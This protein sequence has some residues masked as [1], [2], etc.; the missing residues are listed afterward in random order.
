MKTYKRTDVVNYANK[1]YS[2]NNPD[3]TWFGKN[4]N[5]QQSPIGGNGDCANFVSQ[6]LFE[7]GLPFK[8]TGS[9]N[10]KWY[11]YTKGGAY[12]RK[13]SSWSGANDLRIFVHNTKN[14][15]RLNVKTVA[16]ANRIAEI[17][18]GD[19]IFLLKRAAS[20]EREKN[21]IEAKHVAIVKSI[22]AS[23]QI[24]V[25]QHTPYNC[26][27]WKY[28]GNET[29]LYHIYGIEDTDT[30]SN[31][32]E[33]SYLSWQ[34][35]YG[36]NTFVKSNKYSGNVYRFQVDMNKWR[37]SHGYAKISED[38]LWGSG[39]VAATLLFQQAYGDLSNDGKAG[40]ATKAKLFSI[41]G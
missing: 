1:W 10:R 32:G 27:V 22:S 36:K 30:G 19:L 40:P 11:Y 34:A 29:A 37:L 3:Y 14:A 18:R 38:G 24:T 4:V 39:S 20:S 15:P 7:G 16:W 25:Y 5:G 13:S 6:C 2:G 31:T 41:C 33:N 9:E 35:K 21:T 28:K 12:N 26:S 17:E 8:E 23:G